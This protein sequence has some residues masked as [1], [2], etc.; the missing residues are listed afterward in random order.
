MHQVSVFDPDSG[1]FR[2]LPLKRINASEFEK[3]EVSKWRRR[4]DIYG[5]KSF[6]TPE[7]ASVEGHREH[8]TIVTRSSDKTEGKVFLTRLYFS[9]LGLKADFQRV[10][11]SKHRILYIGP[12][13]DD[14]RHKDSRTRKLKQRVAV[15]FLVLR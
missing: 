11:S 3:V 2:R 5:L 12:M 14:R 15:G 9:Q 13:P 10:I 4:F 8:Y 6:E 1:D 7:K